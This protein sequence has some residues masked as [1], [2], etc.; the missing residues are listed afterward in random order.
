MINIYEYPGSVRQILIVMTIISMLCQ[1]VVLI[2][3]FC[4][5]N[6]HCR[7]RKTAAACINLSLLT[8]TGAFLIILHNTDIWGYMVFPQVCGK[9]GALYADMLVSV[10]MISGSSAFIM[11][12]DEIAY[13]KGTI[14]RLSIREAADK[15][16]TGIMFAETSGRIIL[17]NK[18]MSGI[19][20]IICGHEI[21]HANDF[22][23]TVCSGNVPD[24]KEREDTAS[25]ILLRFND[26]TVWELARTTINIRRHAYYQI[27]ADDRTVADRVMKKMSETNE[28][29]KEQADSVKGV[30]DNIETIKREK[31]I[32][33]IKSRVHDV[34]GER[35]SILQK[36]I[37]NGLDEKNNCREI[38]PMFTELMTS[39]RADVT[40]PPEI[41]MRNLKDSFRYIGME[42]SVN[43]EMPQNEKKAGLFIQII[44]EAA[45]NAVRHAQAGKVTADIFRKDGMIGMQ[46]RNDGKKPVSDITEGGGL[47]GMKQKVAEAGGSFSV[48][49]MPEFIINVSLPE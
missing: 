9:Y 30:I 48:T 49:A 45:T 40:T 19:S 27:V 13:R 39:I 18:T 25:G 26:G 47:G 11:L 44:R 22:W 34:M 23:K 1:T 37:D 20:G 8:V 42:L 36:F 5:G 35:I 32:H 24:M 38:L 4:E 6:L 16:T 10:L 43:G 29:L 12:R 3:I 33:D 17:M 41:L 31:E 28:K 15:L 14:T 2:Y 7:R 46:I 21:R